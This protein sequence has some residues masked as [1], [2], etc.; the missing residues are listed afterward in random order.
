MTFPVAAKAADTFSGSTLADCT[1][2][3]MTSIGVHFQMVSVGEKITGISK[4][5]DQGFCTTDRISRPL[6]TCCIG[7]RVYFAWWSY[8]SSSDKAC[9]Q[10]DWIH[11]LPKYI[12]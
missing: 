7:H 12:I 9:R 5:N 10:N 11:M 1:L 6:Q 2:N 3:T 4:N 8:L